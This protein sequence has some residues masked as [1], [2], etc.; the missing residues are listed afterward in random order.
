[1]FKL[2]P[3]TQTFEFKSLEEM[4]QSFLA[5]IR[6][7]KEKAMFFFLFDTWDFWIS[8]QTFQKLFDSAIFLCNCVVERVTT[9]SGGCMRPTLHVVAVC[10]CMVK[11]HCG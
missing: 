2:D 7:W 11:R 8:S 4:S 9:F 3:Q 5:S 6:R 10:C 1:M